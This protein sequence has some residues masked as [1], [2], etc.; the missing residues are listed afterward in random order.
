MKQ[1]NTKKNIIYNTIY[2]IIKIIIPLIVAPYVSR[3]LGASGVGKYSYY[4]SIANYFLMFAVLGLANYGV[5]EIALC[6]TKEEKIKTFSEI[7]SMQV[8]T[9]LLI[10]IVY[11]V[12]IIIFKN[13]FITIFV[14]YIFSGLFDLSW[15]FFGQNNFSKV[16]IPNIIIRIVTTIFIFLTIKSKNDLYIYCIYMCINY[17][18]P[19]ILVWIIGIKD[20][21]INY[22]KNI[23]TIIKHFKNNLTLFIPIIA[24]SIYKTMDK[25]ML[26]IL[27]NY[28]NVGLYENSE[29]IISV[30]MGFISA[31]GYVM[32]PKVASNIAKNKLSE[33]YISK[34]MEYVA[35]LIVPTIF[36]VFAISKYFI[37]IF[38]GDEFYKSIKIL[39]VLIIS[40]LFLGWANIIRTQI[41]IPY[42]MDKIYINSVIIGAIVN[43]ILNL[44]LI[45]K[46]ESI[47]VSIA[48]VI[49]E[50]T[51][52]I[53][54]TIKVKNIIDIRKNIRTIGKAIIPSI[55]MYLSVQFIDF[56]NNYQNLIIKFAICVI[57]YIVC[58][59]II[60]K[61]N[62]KGV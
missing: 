19:N 34:S 13:K 30:P 60:N 14:I 49:A 37:P 25:I 52:C 17:I 27:T 3:I 54:Q 46:L 61:K 45:K 58:Y 39:N 8:V 56:N 11:T 47:G 4:Y 5:R 48:T 31:L 53:Y 21:K 9:S 62:E 55:I 2:Q 36:G 22:I 29:K 18:I 12:I 28:I 24:I 57:V 15:Y 26:G 35:F 40:T 6:K 44:I 16:I 32:I 42:K 33:N 59:F 10:L 38:Y 23:S 41:L 43:L 20:Y 50:M 7:Y 51:V 1:N